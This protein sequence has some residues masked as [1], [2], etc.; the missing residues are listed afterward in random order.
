MDEEILVGLSLIIVL[1]ISVQ[2][3]AWKLKL[4]SIL[5][6]IITGI[7]AGPVFGII[8]PD[9]YFG[10]LLFPIISLSVAVILFEGGLN[11]KIRE[12]LHTGQVLRNLITI[13]IAVTWLL[14]T[15]G[16][17]FILN[18]ELN[19]S[20]LIGA[21][22]VVTGPTVIIP[23]IKEIKLS[24]QIS[25]LVK[26]EG[27]VNDPIGALLT[28]L[29]FEGIIAEGFQALTA[30]TIWSI[31]KTVLF[32]SAV[33]FAGTLLI[34]VLIKYNLL[35]EPLQSPVTVASVV[36]VFTLSNAIQLESGLF[37]V[38][39]MGIYMMNQKTAPIKSI[40][41]F[42]ENLR[43]LLISFL[44]IVLS[45]R[46]EISTL[47][48]LDLKSFLFVGFLILLVRPAAVY[49][50]TIKS[51]LSWKEKLMLAWMAPRGIVAAAVASLMSIKLIDIGHSDS[52]YLVP[53]IFLVIVLTITVYG[54][55]ARPLG[56]WLGLIQKDLQGCIILGAHEFARSIGKLLKDEG[57]N[58]LMIDTNASNIYEAKKL[59]LKTFHGSILSEHIEDE[60]DISAYGR[61]LALTHNEEVNSLAALYFSDYFGRNEVY[62]L[63]IE[64]DTEKQGQNVSKELRGRILFDVNYTYEYLEKYYVEHDIK[65]AV[66]E[67]GFS[68]EDLLLMHKNQEL[69]PLFLIS[70][71]RKLQIFSVNDKPTP[72]TGEKL[73]YLMN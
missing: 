71:G 8:H 62:Q 27:I 45:A 61:L 4:P 18:L 54:L 5:F 40:V 37:A 67:N 63:S 17:I 23:I 33:G 72:R 15:L 69:I 13:G 34:I 60:I 9:E 10:D 58:V 25:S 65:T 7:L 73:V 12:L 14:T 64:T 32:A 31:A 57:F 44:F 19:I 39:I 22:L 70:S 2:W 30:H 68:Y 11:L 56:R 49:F 55:T 66:F 36:G 20:I 42:K 52:E 21:I 51:N 59:G 48:L 35:P 16:A 26:W 24:G 50:S 41:M 43:I 6:L 29:V 46:I 28:I 38:T 1:G 53:V 3:I 47:S